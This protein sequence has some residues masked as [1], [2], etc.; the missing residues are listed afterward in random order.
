MTAFGQYFQYL[1]RDLTLA[2]AG[3]VGVGIHPDG[4][5]FGDVA[6][7][8]EFAPQQFRG[9]DLGKEP[10]FKIEARRQAEI[11]V[12]GPREAIN[13]ARSYDGSN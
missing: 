11:A 3:L 5:V 7:L 12:R 4:D 13:A 2:L 8:G 10:G 9:I 1:A 6:R